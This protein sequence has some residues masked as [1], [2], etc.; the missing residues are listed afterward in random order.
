MNDPSATGENRVRKG[1]NV[2]ARKRGA[3]VARAN[4]P[5]HPFRATRPAEHAAAKRGPHR[6][7]QEGIRYMGKKGDSFPH[8][9]SFFLLFPLSTTFLH[10]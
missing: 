8:L 4:V 2:G 6:N 7:E 3:V 9:M 5:P 1:R 10:R